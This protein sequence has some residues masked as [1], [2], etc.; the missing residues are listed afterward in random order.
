MK[1]MLINATQPEELRVA[2]VDGQKLID[3]DIE[4]PTG[5]KKSNIYKAIITR[6]E[7][8]LEAAFVDYG[9]ERHGFLPFKEVAR[10]YYRPDVTASRPSI[11]EALKE[12]QDILVQVEKEERG[13]KGAALTT[14]IALPGRFLVLMPNNPR[15][16]GI[17]RRIEGAER[18]ELREKLSALNIPEGMGLIVRTAAIGKSLEELQWDLDYLLHLWEG[19]QKA[20][21]ECKAPCL[22]YQESNMV[23]RAIRDY[24]R[25][26]IDEVIIDTPEV[27]EEARN[28]MQQVMPHNLKKLKLYQD[29][30]PLFTR[31]HIESQ[32]ET[33][34]QREVPLPA[35]GSIVI[36]RTE[37]LVSIDVNSGKATR[38]ADIETTALNTNLEAADEIARQLRLRDLGGLIVIDFI[39]MVHARNQR[40]V[41]SHL[42]EALRMDRARVQVGHI[43]RFGLLEMSRQRLGS[44]L[45]E[46][47]QI[48]CPR[49][50]GQGHIRS[51]ESLSLSILRLLEEEACR[52]HAV[53]IV[54]KLP[55]SV[56]TYLLNEKRHAIHAIEEQHRVAVT[57]IPTPTLETPHYEIERL[58]SEQEAKTPSYQEIALPEPPE[59]PMPAEIRPLEPMV[60]ARPSLPP[61]EPAL[62][63]QSASFIKRLWAALFG[64]PP[65]EEEPPVKEKPKT[66]RPRSGAK[67]TRSRR[68]RTRP[69]ASA[70]AK[71]QEK[72]AESPAEKEAQGTAEVSPAPKRRT[73]T[74][75]RRRAPRKTKPKQEAP[76]AE[77]SLAEPVAPSSAENES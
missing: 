4:T 72:T 21:Q 42:K 48:I 70:E 26:D 28:F 7:P 30:L 16:G 3:L 43:S 66:P 10:T 60:K 40:Q 63:K 73:P 59:I 76:K 68:P 18:N 58:R 53:R 19:I 45:G 34:F 5:Q 74:G 33:A 49:C 69:A 29:K 2:I 47:S 71:N 41:E 25:P 32:I 24:L 39:D 17:S 23:V 37:A 1:R 65:A 22:I 44:S 75:T 20:Y 64:P 50:Q 67:R 6:I 13:T 46:T 11:K 31:Y 54:A 57:L 8:S 77:N 52:D 15:A 9:G 62:E 51:V 35:G 36:D 12:G 27:Y 38:G 55:L 14:F 61:P 56:A